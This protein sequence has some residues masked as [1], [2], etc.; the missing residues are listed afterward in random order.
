MGELHTLGIGEDLSGMIAR[1]VDAL[2]FAA[3]LVLAEQRLHH[4]VH[5]PTVLELR[6]PQRRV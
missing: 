3:G 2:L 6:F 4:I 1:R 5:E